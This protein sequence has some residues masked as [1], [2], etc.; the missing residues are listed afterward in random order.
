MLAEKYFPK[1]TARYQ[2]LSELFQKL[3]S[4]STLKPER[5]FGVLAMVLAGANVAGHVEN[6]WLYW[7]WSTFSY[8]L[9]AIM[10]MAIVLDNF[11]FRFLLFSQKVNS[12]KSGSFMFLIGFFLF[13]LGTLPSG[14]DL[15]V[16]AYGL[17]Y[18]VFFVVA[19][20]T[21]AIPIVENGKGRKFAPEKN[22]MIIPLA[23]TVGLSILTATA[24]VINDDPIISTISSVYLPF[25]LVALIFPAAVRHL[26][27]CRAYVIFIPLMFLSV[28][29]PWFLIPILL[30]FWVLRHYNYF[31][32]GTVSPSF[33]VDLPAGH[34][35]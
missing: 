2:F 19:H 21:Y 5:W 10:V 3:D 30:L 32:H 24:G 28:R 11:M 22:Q 12:I 7:D 34:D 6:R 17:P 27:R 26:Q 1:G 18:F 20:L 33:K 8:F 4:F 35:V 14:F 31:R 13:L 15:L 9:G 29:F 25:A 23:V 16:F